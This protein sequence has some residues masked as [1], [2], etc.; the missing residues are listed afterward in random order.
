MAELVLHVKD[1]DEEGKDYA[2]E[3]TPA[4]LDATLADAALHA[5]P[6]FPPG[7][8]RVHAQKNGNDEYLVSG[9][10]AAHL[11]TE[12]GRC[13]GPAPVPVAVEF[14]TLFSHGSGKT[15]PTRSSRAGSV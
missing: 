3:L 7:A 6:A 1:I 2:F 11:V 4:W 14:A 9:S 8:L 12:C 13:L 5:D 10:I 15:L